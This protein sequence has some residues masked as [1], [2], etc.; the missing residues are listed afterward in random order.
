MV[1]TIAP[2]VA[3][4]AVALIAPIPA[5]PGRLSA[6]PT[7]RATA[8]VTLPIWLSVAMFSSVTT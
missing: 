8:A 3:S 4:P 1:T 2:T 5:E 7:G 6:W